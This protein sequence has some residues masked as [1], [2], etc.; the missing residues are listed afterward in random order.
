MS[1]RA[2]SPLSTIVY[3]TWW[4]TCDCPAW[5]SHMPS[6]GWWGRI[7]LSLQGSRRLFIIL[8]QLRQRKSWFVSYCYWV[9]GCF[10]WS[11]LT[12]WSLLHF[13]FSLQ[14]SPPTRKFHTFLF[15][16]HRCSNVSLF[17]SH[18]MQHRSPFWRCEFW[19]LAINF[20]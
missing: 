4:I 7:S 12:A 5:N 20:W 13:S 6:T 18:N 8:V 9:W 19:L 3:N 16:W 15:S 10:L 1:C 14:S 11:W 17:S 2:I